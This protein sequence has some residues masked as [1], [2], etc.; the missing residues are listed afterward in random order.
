MRIGVVSDTHMYSRAKALPAA[1]VRGLVGVDLILHA[2][3]WVDEEVVDLFLAIAPV[4]A[5]A[6]NN[7]GPSLVRRFGRR[8]ELT[9]GGKKIGMVHG[10][11]GR[12]TAETAFHSFKAAPVDLIVF[13]HSHIPYL[14][15]RGGVLL[16]NPGSPTDKRR[17]PKYSFGIVTLGETI[18]AEHHYYDSKEA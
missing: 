17:Q 9:L 18:T 3:D 7:D 11:G 5:I 6:G 16:F 14:E 15:R 8:K 2:G 1:L 10:D 4:E 13:G 12:Q